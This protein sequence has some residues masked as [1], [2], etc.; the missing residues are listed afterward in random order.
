MVCEL[1]LLQCVNYPLICGRADKSPQL[2][3][4]KKKLIK[5]RVNQWNKWKCADL[6][7]EQKKCFV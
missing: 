2:N 5:R 6:R 7:K 4:E 3:G 1:Q